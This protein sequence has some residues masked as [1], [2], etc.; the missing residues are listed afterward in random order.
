MPHMITF[1][2]ELTMTK[3][4]FIQVGHIFLQSSD[5]DQQNLVLHEREEEDCFIPNDMPFISFLC[6][7]IS[8]LEEGWGKCRLTRNGAGYEAWTCLNGCLIHVGEVSDTDKHWTC[9]DTYQI[10]H[11]ACPNFC[12]R[13]LPGHMKDTPWTCVSATQT[14][15]KT[16]FK[17][18]PLFLESFFSP[19]T[20]ITTH[21]LIFFIFFF[22]FE[23]KGSILALIILLIS[24][25][26]LLRLWF[27]ILIDNLLVIYISVFFYVD[28]VLASI[29]FDYLENK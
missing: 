25:S 11:M 15:F 22:H 18:S 2:V 10:C 13:I 26:F 9:L 28:L 14:Y 24:N 12:I 3:T 27:V 7:T 8:Y 6:G 17:C 1:S 23:W 20:L 29:S 5:V 21:Y 4:C 16:H 19:Y